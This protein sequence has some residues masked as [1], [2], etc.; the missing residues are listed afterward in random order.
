V[1]Y[2]FCSIKFTETKVLFILRRKY[3]IIEV[4][5]MPISVHGGCTKMY[6]IVLLYGFVTCEAGRKF[7]PVLC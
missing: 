1:Y 2:R 3:S 5:H 7:A 4:I 6:F